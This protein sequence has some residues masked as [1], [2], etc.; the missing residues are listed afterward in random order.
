LKA[1]RRPGP[2]PVCRLRETDLKVLLIADRVGFENLAHFNRVF[3]QTVHL[4][5][6]QY[7]RMSE[8]RA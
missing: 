5:P 1:A 3:K 4:S 7:R 2:D 8:Q 6:S